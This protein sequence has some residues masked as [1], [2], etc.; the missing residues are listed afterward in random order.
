MD[1]SV[2]LGIPEG[3]E[4]I[5]MVYRGINEDLIELTLV[6]VREME[7]RLVG[8]HIR[9]RPNTQLSRHLLSYLP[10]YSASSSS[11]S[12]LIATKPLNHS[13]YKR[14]RVLLRR[15]ASPGLHQF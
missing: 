11:C 7:G 2:Y 10:R 12:A 6:G 8:G 1:S 3:K 5:D 15:G 13:F 14:P 9:N 4:L